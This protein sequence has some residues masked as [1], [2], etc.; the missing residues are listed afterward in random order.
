MRYLIAAGLLVLS[1][2][3]VFAGGGAPRKE[4]MPKYIKTIKN[5]GAPAKVKTEAIEMIGKRGAV[6]S[7]DVDDAIEPL[8]ALAQKDKDAGVRKAAV[9]ALGSIAPDASA[10]VP[11]LIQ[12]LKSDK[13][14]DVK[15]ASVTAL[16]RYGPE[17]KSAL[18]A[19]R[20]FGKSLDK[21]Q[22]QPI[23]A[24]TLAINGTKK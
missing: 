8:K 9:S 22:Q 2:G 11:I 10:T 1:F 14:Q 16:G 18:P 23:R 6:N 15:L 12:V 4:D 20:E 3:F 21:K 19:I 17:A 7:R 24:A 5:P 13:S